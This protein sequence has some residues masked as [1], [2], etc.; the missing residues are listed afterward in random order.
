MIRGTVSLNPDEARADMAKEQAMIKEG[1][2]FIPLRL[3]DQRKAKIQGAYVLEAIPYLDPATNTT[4]YQFRENGGELKFVFDDFRGGFYAKMLKCEW[5]MRFLA[6]HLSEHSW[7][8]VD[9][10][11]AAEVKAIESEMI[12]NNTRKADEDYEVPAES[13][14]TDE[15][16]E[17]EMARL[18]QEAAKRKLRQADDKRAPVRAQV[19]A[20]PEEPKSAGPSPSDLA[21]GELVTE[22]VPPVGEPELPPD[23]PS[24]PEGGFVQTRNKGGRPKKVA[25]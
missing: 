4:R 3:I 15:E 14:L 24:E 25:A 10:K 2:E 20:T 22:S 1:R 5:N 16:L 23:L 18:Q 6:S 21:L 8:I 12:I 7:E 9:E 19:Q 13:R 11:V 17:T